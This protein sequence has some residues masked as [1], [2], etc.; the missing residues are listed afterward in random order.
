MMI[1]RFAAYHTRWLI[2][3]PAGST[4]GQSSGALSEEINATENICHIRIHK[5][6]IGIILKCIFTQKYFLICERDTV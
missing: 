3:P 1:G 5:T 2:H 6:Q 4:A